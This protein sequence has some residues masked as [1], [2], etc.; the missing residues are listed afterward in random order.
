MP[1]IIHRIKKAA[2]HH[3]EPPNI[4]INLNLMKQT[5]YYLLIFFFP[6]EMTIPLA[7]AFTRWP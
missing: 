3:E 4:T 5:T 2:P 7:S 6:L 1:D